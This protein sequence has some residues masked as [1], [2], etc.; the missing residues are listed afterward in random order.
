M[1]F[2]PRGE[3]IAMASPFMWALG[4]TWESVDSQTKIVRHLDWGVFWTLGW[5]GLAV[6][7]LA[8][9]VLRFDRALGRVEDATLRLSHG[10]RTRVQSVSSAI[11][12]GWVVF[13]IIASCL[14]P[15][16]AGPFINGA[17][18][19]GGLLL[20]GVQA[21]LSI[22]ADRDNGTLD[23]AWR[24]GFSTLGI[25]LAK[26]V[27]IGGFVLPMAFLSPLIVLCQNEPVFAAWQGM[28]LL[29]AYVI[30]VGGTFAAL[31]L[32]MGARFS[33]GWAAALSVVVGTVFSLGW[34]TL[35]LVL[36]P[37]ADSRW[38]LLGSPYVGVGVVTGEL[39]GVPGRGIYDLY[40]VIAWMAVHGV[41]AVGLLLATATILERG[42]I[43]PM[44][45]FPHFRSARRPSG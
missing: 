8:M 5:G 17:L 29:V 27:G 45:D 12:V 15:H 23:D 21:A 7:L 10:A 2:G 4:V 43:R 14:G 26:W 33:Q 6:A 28:V 31:G 44:G 13:M 16:G 1:L 32:A 36:L 11:C 42:A 34:V 30:C 41:A 24:A 18:V 38:L 25:V 9:T 35:V 37:G 22:A 20:V 40:W 19:G 39:M 3:G